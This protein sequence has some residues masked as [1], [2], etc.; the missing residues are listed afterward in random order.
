MA[1]NTVHSD[2]SDGTYTNDRNNHIK[3]YENASLAGG[4]L[5][6]LDA[7]FEGKSMAFGYGYDLFQNLST[8]QTDLAPFV[9]YKSPNT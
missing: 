9:S 8:L 7:H 3:L 2:W 6:F 1:L 4:N 5:N